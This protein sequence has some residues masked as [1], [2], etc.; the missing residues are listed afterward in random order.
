MRSRAVSCFGIASHN[1]NG[2]M[3]TAIPRGYCCHPTR[4]SVRSKNATDMFIP[5]SDPSSSKPLPIEVNIFRS[6]RCPCGAHPLG[7]YCRRHPHPG[8]HPPSSRRGPCSYIHAELTLSIPPA[9]ASAPGECSRSPR[10]FRREAVALILDRAQGRARAWTHCDRVSRGQDAFF[11]WR[12]R[13]IVLC[14]SRAHP[15]GGPRL[16]ILP[17]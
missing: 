15:R 5:P 14:S 8:G 3:S 13:G 1:P 6:V 9:K 11:A 2:P 10:P 17:K 16:Y 4:Q 7:P 12:A